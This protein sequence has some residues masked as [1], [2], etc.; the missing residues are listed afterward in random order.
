MIY[1]PF[2]LLW[3]QL[4]IHCYP[5]IISLLIINN[6]LPRR[7]Y[8]KRQVEALIKIVDREIIILFS[9][10]FLLLHQST[11]RYTWCDQ[12]EGSRWKIKDMEKIHFFLQMAY[13]TNKAI[14]C[15]RN[16]LILLSVCDMNKSLLTLRNLR[17]KTFLY[18]RTNFVGTPV[19][20]ENL[21]DLF[22]PI[23]RG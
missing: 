13:C 23:R 18:A 6:T 22:M 7:G 20:K 4:Y 12:W 11:W 14:N 15:P 16:D 1:K 19:S 17:C 10:R 8:W 3:H 5:C 2:L 21:P 9:S